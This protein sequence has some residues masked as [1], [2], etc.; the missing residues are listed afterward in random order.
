MQTVCQDT[1]ARMFLIQRLSLAMQRG[2]A[3]YILGTIADDDFL[4]DVHN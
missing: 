4:T 2:N 3:A 1:I